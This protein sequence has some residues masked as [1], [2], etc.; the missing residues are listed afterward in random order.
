MWMP[1]LISHAV[2]HDGFYWLVLVVFIAGVVRGFS[3][4]GTAMVFI[5]FASQFMDPVS[6]LVALTVMDIF[7]PIPN[8]P[9]AWRDGEPSSVARLGF[10]T[11][12][13]LPAGI[14][15]LLA[16]PAEIFRYAVSILAI[17]VP[18]SLLAGLR[19]RGQ[20]TPKL[21]YV[22]GAVAGITG[23]AVGLP[24]PPIIM[25]FAASTKAVS[26][27]RANIMMYL[28]VFDVFLLFWL[29]MKGHLE[30]LPI[31]LGLLF[32]VPS[33]AGNILGAKVFDP[34]REKLY[35][36]IAYLVIFT[37]A[38]TSLPLWD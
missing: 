9:R 25:L 6:V 13:A 15:F 30:A 31:T 38:L 20:I 4:F 32:L 17:V 36:G 16:V 10:A 27:I 21:L 34:A 22:G 33:V 26:C 35:R 29:A 5:P 24:G 14:Y 1:E 37:A 28:F 8:L 3:G 23:G 12:V 19:Y 7:G 18:L 11:L 2:Q